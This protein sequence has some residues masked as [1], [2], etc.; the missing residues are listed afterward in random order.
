MADYSALPAIDTSGHI[1][2]VVDTP[3]GSRAKYKYDRECGLFRLSKLL[4]AGAVFPGNF[5]FIPGT[6][7]KDGDEID[8]LILGHGTLVMGAV[9]TVRLI[10]LLNVQQTEDGKTVRNNHLLGVI[11]T[12]HNPAELRDIDELHPHHVDEI[13]HFFTGYNQMEGRQFEVLVREDAEAALR[14]VKINS[15]TSC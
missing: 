5:G 3:R 11:E 8:V 6:R 1:T 12:N 2:V 15:E 10:G 14:Y 7:G 13:I 9:V 4:P